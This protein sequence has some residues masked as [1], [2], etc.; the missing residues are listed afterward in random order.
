MPFSFGEGLTYTTFNVSAASA[1]FSACAASTASDLKCYTVTVEY[2][3]GLY[4]C[5]ARGQAPL[6]VYYH[7]GYK[8]AKV[9]DAMAPRLGGRS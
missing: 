1:D 7:I 2:W 4:V 6:T 3:G 8:N 9:P 5:V